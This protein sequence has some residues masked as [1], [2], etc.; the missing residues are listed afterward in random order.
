L[1]FKGSEVFA[2]VPRL[3]L[4]MHALRLCLTHQKFTNPDKLE[5]LKVLDYFQYP[6]GGYKYLYEKPNFLWEK[7]F[8]G[9]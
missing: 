6:P 5:F 3:R 1:G 4:G 8:N 9:A 2:L 7:A